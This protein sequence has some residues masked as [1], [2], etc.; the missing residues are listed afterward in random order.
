MNTFKEVTA[1]NLSLG[2]RR[3]VYGIGINDATYMTNQIIDG[4]RSMCPYYR[5]WKDMLSRCYSSKI[6]SRFQTYKDCTVAAEWL[7]FMTFRHWMAEQ[8]WEDMVLDKDIKFS[9]NKMYSPETCLLIPQPLNKLF[10]DSKAKRGHL[11]QGVSS[12]KISGKYQA[13][14]SINGKRK[15]LGIFQTPEG[16]VKAYKKAKSAIVRQLIS[17]N[18]YPMATQYL[19][20]HL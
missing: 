19:E 15:H 16:A 8:E 10:T 14:I 18:V 1:S 12:Y 2:Q 4:K 17:D 7:S 20:Q 5:K 3:L 6:Q 11:P 13:T 9:G